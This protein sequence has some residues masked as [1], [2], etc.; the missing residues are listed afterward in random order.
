MC[1]CVCMHV[2]M[3]ECDVHKII[4]IL[5]IK[6]YIC[7]R[8]QQTHDKHHSHTCTGNTHAYI[9][10]HVHTYTHTH[11]HTYIHTHTHTHTHQKRTDPHDIVTFAS[12][13]SPTKPVNPR[14]KLLKR[15]KKPELERSLSLFST[16]MKRHIIPK[17]DGPCSLSLSLSL[18]C[19]SL[20][21][22]LSLSVSL[23]LS[24]SFSLS[25]VYLSFSPSLS[26]TLLSVFVCV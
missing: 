10:T 16:K 13:L 22:S 14:L 2:C 19:L 25:P 3:Y 11:T 9:R 20:S 26:L 8:S 1:V 12:A 18:V 17:P 24:L 4:I 21:L 7:S 23:C 5:I 15:S 6:Q